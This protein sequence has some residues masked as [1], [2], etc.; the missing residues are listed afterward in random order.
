MDSELCD[1]QHNHQGGELLAAG[2]GDDAAVLIPIPAGGSG[3][4]F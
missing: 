4:G 2:I 1:G 3:E